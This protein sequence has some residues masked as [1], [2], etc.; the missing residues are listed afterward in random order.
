M[1]I[2]EFSCDRPEVTFSFLIIPRRV[3]LKLGWKSNSSDFPWRVSCSSPRSGRSQVKVDVL[4]ERC[5]LFHLLLGIWSFHFFA[6]WTLPLHWA[7]GRGVQMRPSPPIPRNIPGKTFA[8]NWCNPGWSFAEIGWYS[9]IAPNGN[10]GPSKGIPK[11][12]FIWCPPIRQE[13]LN[14][15]QIAIAFHGISQPLLIQ[16]WL[17][18]YC[19][20]S[21]FHSAYCPF[22]NPIS[23][24]SVWCWRPMIPG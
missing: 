23:F 15:A 1:T 17:Q 11:P 24:W 19:W 6:A 3:V 7:F 18:Q 16:S 20:I 4:T 2:N 14:V 21:F 22:S 10:T 8:P 5:L 12:P 13:I 9:T